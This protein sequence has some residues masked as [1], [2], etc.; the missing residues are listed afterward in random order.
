VIH[1]AVAWHFVEQYRRTSPRIVRLW[2]DL[3]AVIP[4]LCRED[5]EIHE[6]SYWPVTLGHH[7]VGMPDGSYIRY[8]DLRET[9]RDDYDRPV[10]TYMGRG[11]S[12]LKLYG[13]LLT[14]NVVQGIARC[15]VFDQ[16]LRIQHRLRNL[17]GTKSPV[18]FTVHDEVVSMVPGEHARAALA[19]SL[20]EMRTLP[21][22]CEGLPIAATGG[23]GQ[24]YGEAK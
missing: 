21:S 24:N 7:R 9:G 8:P 4:I 19:A 17:C 23:I 18:T 11:K 15:V 1:A 12:R 13:G 5:A 22:W 2:K 3:Q 14:E 6:L 16:A 20:Q 10:Y